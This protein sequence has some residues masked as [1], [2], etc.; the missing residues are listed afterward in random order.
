M[1]DAWP[2]SHLPP[3][4]SHGSSH[5]VPYVRRVPHV[6]QV[7][8]HALE[9]RVESGGYRGENGE[10]GGACELPAGGAGQ[11]DRFDPNGKDLPDHY[12]LLGVS[13]DATDKQLKRA[14]RLM[15]LKC[16]HILVQYSTSKT[17]LQH[18]KKRQ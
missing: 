12:T 14:Y 17:I 1:C 3:R 13:A 10:K 11:A 7:R 8:A 9:K 4:M 2:T 16:V 18:T 15:S 5:L 6:V